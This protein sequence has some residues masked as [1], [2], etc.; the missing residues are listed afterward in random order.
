MSFTATVHQDSAEIIDNVVILAGKDKGL[1]ILRVFHLKKK[2]SLYSGGFFKKHLLLAEN[3][4]T[5]HLV[6]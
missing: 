6:L 3:G 1:I 4:L 2:E 5:L